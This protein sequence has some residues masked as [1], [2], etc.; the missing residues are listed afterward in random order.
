M[1]TLLIALALSQDGG[2]IT[3]LEIPWND[4]QNLIDHLA[5]Y[6]ELTSLSFAGY[7]DMVE[8]PASL[9]KLTHL[10]ELIIDNGNGSEMNPQL[11][12]WFGELRTLET[13]VLFGAQDPITEAPDA[14]PG[15]TDND[16]LRARH[17]WPK[18]MAQLKNLTSLNIG[19]N[20]LGEVPAFVQQLP[21]LRVLTLSFDS[22]K[23][24]PDGLG[25]LRELQELNLLGNDLTDLPRS[26]E[27]LPA[28]KKITL[29]NNCALTHNEKKKAELKKRFPKVTLDFEDMY[30]C[31]D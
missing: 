9:R 3:R 21:H 20:R 18:S 13:L 24:L 7:E 23:T 16:K 2:V 31:G 12:E 10:K 1:L 17:P 27:K 29:G 30:D 26:L 8:L 14:Q 25:Q 15:T 6:P 4:K 22:L 5:D 11:P 28:L 19:R